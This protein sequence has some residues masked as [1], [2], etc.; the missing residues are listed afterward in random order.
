MDAI[1]LVSGVLFFFFF[2]SK[3]LSVHFFSSLLSL[4]IAHSW[5]KYIFYIA[6]SPVSNL[7]MEPVII[8]WRSDGRHCLDPFK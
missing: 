4:L 5:K 3:S 2:F 8:K 1:E 7:R 6:R